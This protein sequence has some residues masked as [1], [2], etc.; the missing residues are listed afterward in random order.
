MYCQDEVDTAYIQAVHGQSFVGPRKL[1]IIYSPLHG[2][3]CSAVVPALAADGFA[4]V[5]VFGPQA[6]PT[7][8]FPTSLAMSNPENDAVFDAIIVRGKQAGGRFDPRFGSRL[9]SYRSCRSATVNAAGPWATMTG[10]QIGA[11]AGRICART[12][13]EIRP[14]LAEHYMVKTLVTTELARRIA[15][16]YGVE[17]YGN[18]QVGFKY[19]RRRRSMSRGPTDSFSAPRNRT[20]IWPARTLAIRTRQWPRCSW[21]NWPRAESRRANTE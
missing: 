9:R 17:T 14:P 11:I 21:P 2:V 8:I 18:L 16:A 19:H 1:K 3:G 10:N 6:E 5:E 12:T 20:D 15:E 13:Q 7:V 4:D